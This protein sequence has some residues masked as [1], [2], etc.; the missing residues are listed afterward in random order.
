MTPKKEPLV[1][2]VDPNGDTLTTLY[3]ILDREGCLVATSHPDVDAL[4]YVAAH[5]P[6][7]AL[8]GRHPEDA[9]ARLLPI[10]IRRL[11]PKTRVLLFDPSLPWKEGEKGVRALLEAV[12]KP[13]RR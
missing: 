3:S 12:R 1:L 10:Q 8:V 7:V 11:S 2:L 13:S 5:Q 6:D 9:P 4:R